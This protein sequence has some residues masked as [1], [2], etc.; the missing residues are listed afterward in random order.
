MKSGQ[1]KKHGIF[2]ESESYIRKDKR[3]K[4]GI[5]IRCAKCVK[6]QQ[7]NATLR[8]RKKNTD[9]WCHLHGDLNQ[10]NAYACK[11]GENIRYRCKV[12]CQKKRKEQYDG[13]RD[14]AIKSAATWKKANRSHVNEQVR[15]DKKNNPE[16]YKKWN[17]AYYSNNRKR[18]SI[19]TTG[20]ALG[21]TVDQYEQMERDQNNKCAI[22]GF[23]ETRKARTAGNICRLAVDHDHETGTIRQLLCSDCNTTLGKMK[24]S[25]DLLMQA[26]FYLIDHGKDCVFLEVEDVIKD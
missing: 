19:R 23:E 12:C 6:E 3:Y 22:C 21:I 1:C 24:D 9:T 14:E 20:Y 18:I 26:A 2:L 13:N 7:L 15:E 16:K 10:D 25:P 17:D 4:D 8:I 11:S 5:S